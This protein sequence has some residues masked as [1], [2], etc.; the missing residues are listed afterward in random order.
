MVGIRR[1]NLRWVDIDMAEV[2]LDKLIVHFAQSN[3]A[4]G[5]SPKTISWYS[6]MLDGFKR[7]LELKGCKGVLYE[8]DIQTVR[9]FVVHEQERGMSP[10]TVQGK[11]RALKAFSSWLFR[12]AYTSDNLIGDFKLPKVP[13][14]LIEPLTS[15][16]IEQL[17]NCQNPLTAIGC[18]DIAIIILMLDSG[19][20]LSELCTL[21]FTNAH[22]EEGYLKVMGKGSKERLGACPS[23]T[24]GS[25]TEV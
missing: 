1:K 14:I 15:G 17:V 8:F 18:R 5:K 16:E 10:Y 2:R 24:L 7:F 13:A 20:R 6:E 3:R 4:D 25:A 22:V 9:E 12:E 23:N 11:V 19:I 21:H